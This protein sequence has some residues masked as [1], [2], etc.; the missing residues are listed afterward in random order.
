ME[1]R[2]DGNQKKV[3]DLFLK[4]W[5]SLLQFKLHLA[6]VKDSL[7]RSRVILKH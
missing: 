3:E 6:E 5:K 7:Y 4:K 1:Q 2:W